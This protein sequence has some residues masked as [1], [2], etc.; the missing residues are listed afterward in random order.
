MNIRAVA[1]GSGLVVVAALAA[2]ALI[3]PRQGISATDGALP[4]II[5]V[6]GTGEVKTRPDMAII[7]SG[8]MTE[9]ATAQLRCRKTT[10]P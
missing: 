2:A 7:S 9:G 5:S 4:R 10:K 3:G 6:S 8:V 1:V